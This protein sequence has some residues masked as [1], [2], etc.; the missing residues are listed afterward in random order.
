[1]G[2][3]LVTFIAFSL[4]AIAYAV[5]IDFVRVQATEISFEERSISLDREEKVITL[6]GQD[7]KV[8]FES[9]PKVIDLETGAESPSLRILQ[10][11]KRD[12]ETIKTVTL[13]CE[14]L[15]STYSCRINYAS[16][17]EAG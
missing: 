17:A 11:E 12:S 6:S 13:E 16:G 15:S 9:L 7:L 3:C 10:I 8:L 5:S 1:M 4:G 2:K 14:Q